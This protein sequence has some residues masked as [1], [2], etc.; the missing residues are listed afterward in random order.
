MFPGKGGWA[1]MHVPQ[2]FLNPKHKT[3]WG[4]IPIEAKVRKTQGI[5]GGKKI[6]VLSRL[7]GN[8]CVFTSE[9]FAFRE[10]Y[11]GVLP[12]SSYSDD[13]THFASGE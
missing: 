13:R 10:L 12:L 9:I 6:M 7:L 5:I 11:L 3:P 2:K 4:F 1:H 8:R